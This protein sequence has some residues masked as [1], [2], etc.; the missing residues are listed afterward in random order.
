MTFDVVILSSSGELRDYLAREISQI[1]C[2]RGSN[3]SSTIRVRLV[4]LRV[5]MNIL[6]GGWVEVRE[7]LREAMAVNDPLLLMNA[8]EIV[9]GECTGAGAVENCRNTMIVSQVNELVK[10]ET[11]ESFLRAKAMVALAT[12]LRVASPAITTIFSEVEPLGIINRILEMNDRSLTVFIGPSMSVI[13]KI[14]HR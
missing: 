10:N 7:L 6:D 5:K 14:N 1:D 3:A 9:Q 11:L 2:S 4:T 13:S 8:L 12:V